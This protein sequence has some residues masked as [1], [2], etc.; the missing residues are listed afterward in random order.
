MTY[1]WFI[2]PKLI[3]TTS[4]ISHKKRKRMQHTARTKQ[5]EKQ[6]KGTKF[7]SNYPSRDFSQGLGS[8]LEIHQLLFLVV[9]KALA[10]TVTRGSRGTAASLRTSPLQAC[11]CC[12]PG[13][14]PTCNKMK[15][16]NDSLH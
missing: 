15:S 11:L 8:C 7:T 3:Q 14:A 13:P 12:Q 5:R 1:E 2:T 16:C 10:K 9:D 6:M 4:H